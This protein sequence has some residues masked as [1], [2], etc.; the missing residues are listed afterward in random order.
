MPV[1][2]A[3]LELARGLLS[4]NVAPPARS[5]DGILVARDM[6]RE[7]GT[8]VC[9]DQ[10]RGQ[11]DMVSAMPSDLYGGGT[12]ALRMSDLRISG[13]EPPPAGVFPGA[14]ERETRGLTVPGRRRQAFP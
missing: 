1:Q 9:R 4:G 2:T 14:L 3:G 12:N 5:V 10:D 11:V 7:A 13:D 8:G 6:H